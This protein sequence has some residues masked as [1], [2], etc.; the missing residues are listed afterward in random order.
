MNSN[1]ETYQECLHELYRTIIVVI[2][3]VV[4]LCFS[5][6]TL[7]SSLCQHNEALMFNILYYLK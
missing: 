4:L 6:I 2:Q 1:L 3:Y 7:M 5:D